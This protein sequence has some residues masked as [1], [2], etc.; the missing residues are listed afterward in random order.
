MF[1]QIVLFM[2]QL[3]L[4]LVAVLGMTDDEEDLEI[5]LLREQLLVPVAHFCSITFILS[6]SL[7]HPQ[8]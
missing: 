4:D 6:G 1:F 8:V 2:W 3:M 7:A 5:M